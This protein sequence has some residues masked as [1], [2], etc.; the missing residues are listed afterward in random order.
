LVDT[1]RTGTLNEDQ[2][3][4]VLQLRT[5]ILAFVAQDAEVG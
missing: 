2:K 1:L 4:T 3:Q 5:G